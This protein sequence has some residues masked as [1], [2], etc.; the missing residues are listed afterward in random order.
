M[1]YTQFYVAISSGT[2]SLIIDI[3][4]INKQ[5]IPYTH[6]MALIKP[7]FTKDQ[8]RWISVVLL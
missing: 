1:I 6:V 8:M 2:N 3:I 7:F 4:I 5:I